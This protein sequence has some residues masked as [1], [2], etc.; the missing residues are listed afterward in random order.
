MAKKLK[1]LLPYTVYLFQKDDI[2]YA[3]ADAIDDATKDVI[4]FGQGFKLQEDKNSKLNSPDQILRRARR[5]VVASVSNSLNAVQMFGK[6]ALDDNCEIDWNKFQ[7]AEFRRALT[8]SRFHG[9]NY[10]KKVYDFKVI[11]ISVDT[12]IENKLI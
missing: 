2:I 9:A 1:K 7:E 8:L 10:D 12:A 6:Q 3:V 11:E 4:R 5:S